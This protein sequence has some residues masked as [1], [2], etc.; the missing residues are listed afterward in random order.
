MPLEPSSPKTFHVLDRDLDEK[1]FQRFSSKNSL[2]ID[3]EAMG[4]IHGRDRLCLVQICD[5][6][7]NVICIRI[8]RNQKSAP[9]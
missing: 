1:S 2:A 5:E 3:T 4:L 8:E 7:D 6:S 9:F